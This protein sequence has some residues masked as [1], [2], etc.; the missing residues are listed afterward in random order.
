MPGADGKLCPTEGDTGWA[1]ACYL[2]QEQQEPTL[3]LIC[4]DIPG[5]D[6]V[7]GF[8]NGDS[9]WVKACYRSYEP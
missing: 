7:R 1:E 4:E 9:E 5:A 8:T 2:A 3:D 6:G